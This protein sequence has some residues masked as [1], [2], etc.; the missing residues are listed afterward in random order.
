MKAIVYHRYGDASQLQEADIPS[1]KL[2]PKEVR[3]DVKACE[4]TKA[5]IELREFKFPVKWFAA[6]LRLAFGLFKPR[7]PVLGS[8]ISGT[9]VEVGDEV[10]RFQAGDD[11]YGCTGFRFG[12]YGEQVCLPEA[13]TLGLKPANLSH[14]EA[15][16]TLLGG[17]NAVH[18]MSLATLGPDKTIL[19][20]GSGGS[21]GLMVIQLAKAAGAHVTAV[22]AAHKS[23][24][25][26]RAGADQ[27]IDYQETPLETIETTFDCVFNMIASTPFAS[28]SALLN[29]TGV[30]IT[31]NPKL[32]DMWQCRR[33]NKQGKQHGHFE[34]AGESLD[35]LEL[36]SRH[37]RE[38]TLTPVIDKVFPR[39]LIRAAHERVE[40]E[41]RLGSVV[42]THQP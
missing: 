26:L 29:E 41:Q 18:F 15:A 7:N 40:T 37:L 1:P 35:D 33:L 4:V 17:L 32:S 25:I 42:L 22:D 19:I 10:S 12:G 20:N 31:A 39:N 28:L 23:E 8:Y 30:Y 38:K 11:V 24:L 9:V 16:A 27:I 34:F 36:L 21:I 6:P 14:E 13:Y 2:K 5:D 3:I